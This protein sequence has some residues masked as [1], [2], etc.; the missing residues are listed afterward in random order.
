M[1]NFN[2]KLKMKKSLQLLLILGMLFSNQVPASAANKTLKGGQAVSV[3]YPDTVTL[4]KSGCQD[5]S[6]KYTVAKMPQ[7]SFA[8]M[9]ILDDADSQ[10]GGSTF[11]KTPSADQTGKIWK[12]NGSFN[13]TVCRTDWSRDIGDGEYEDMTGVSKGTY[14]LY[15]MVYPSTEAFATITFK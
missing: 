7:I 3:T 12:K 4:K 13:L 6:F 15:L 14:Q 1:S 5:I 9:A 11:Y 8:Y 10:I 2:R